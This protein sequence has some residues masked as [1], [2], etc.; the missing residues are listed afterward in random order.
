MPL[1]WPTLA[2]LLLIL[3]EQSARKERA[4]ALASGDVDALLEPYPS[5]L[6]RWHAG[7]GDDPRVRVEKTPSS[8]AQVLGAFAQAW[9]EVVEEEPTAMGVLMLSAQSDLETASFS[10]LYNY[11]LGNLTHVTHD[12]HP[13]VTRS[14]VGEAMRF[15]AYPSLLAGACDMVRWAA[16]HKLLD[17]AARG[18][19]DGYVAGL[20]SGCYLGCT[21]QGGVTDA[22]Y[23][24]YQ[25]G[26]LARAR[27]FER[28]QPVAPPPE[29]PP[30]WVVLLGGAMV[31]MGVWW[32]IGPDLPPG[33]AGKT[34]ERIRTVVYRVRGIPSSPAATAA[35]VA[36]DP[37]SGAATMI[38]KDV[39]PEVAITAAVLADATGVLERAEL[40]T[41][42]NL[43]PAKPSSACDCEAA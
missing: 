16:A 14:D 24:T 17:C 12:G 2:V 10:S 19:L 42:Q 8:R 33:L 20:K 28:V 32:A 34:R 38:A 36:I 5:G 15:R 31:A 27:L 40:P 6:F 1:L 22:T 3:R 26:I 29:P 25:S 9:R 11:N 39:T 18:D 37:K 41:T 43:L 30:L 35:A 13:W 21:G 4:E 23:A 7:A